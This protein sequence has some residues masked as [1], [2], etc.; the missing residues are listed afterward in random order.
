MRDLQAQGVGFQEA[1]AINAIPERL[2]A[3]P[4]RDVVGA[5]PKGLARPSRAL[6]R[7]G[8]I[9]TWVWGCGRASH[10]SVTLTP[11]ALATISGP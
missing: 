10:A 5:R 9:S 4:S 2:D 3:A 7:S 11:T 1:V 6:C 8:G